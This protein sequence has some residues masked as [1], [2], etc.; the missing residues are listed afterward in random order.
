MRR[1]PRRKARH[2]DRGLPRGHHLAG[3]DQGG[4]DDAAGI[5]DQRRIGKRV[6]RQFD[7]ALGAIEART[8]F[9]SVLSVLFPAV[10][11]VSLSALLFMELVYASMPIAASV[12]LRRVRTAAY[13]GLTLAFSLIFLLCMNYVVTELVE[14]LKLSPQDANVWLFEPNRMLTGDSPADRLRAG[15]FHQV[16]ALIVALADGIVA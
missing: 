12:E 4:G 6:F 3:I 5:G 15:D 16:H 14:I 13:A 11:V 7:R 10:L 1:S 8:R 9:V 2:A